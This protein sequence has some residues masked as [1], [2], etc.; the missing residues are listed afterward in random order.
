MKKI[1]LI[2][3]MMMIVMSAMADGPTYSFMKGGMGKSRDAKINV[4]SSSQV[5]DSNHKNINA[6]TAAMDFDAVNNTQTAT[7]SIFRF[8]MGESVSASAPVVSGGVAAS[9]GIRAGERRTATVNTGSALSVALF[10]GKKGNDITLGQNGHLALFGDDIKLMD[11][12][13]TDPNAGEFETPRVPLGDAMLP[14]L[15]MIMAF[16]GFVYF[17]KK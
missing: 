1:S 7:R 8:G 11:G 16:A 12:E 17:R 10:N 2:L 6:T 14:L 9:S 5:Y 15:L 13:D 4:V 3:A